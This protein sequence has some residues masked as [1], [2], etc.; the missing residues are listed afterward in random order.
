MKPKIYNIL[1]DAIEDG[2]RYGYQRAHKHTDDPDRA[3]IENEIHNAI[4][5]QIFQY[6]D[7]DKEVKNTVLT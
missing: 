6:F 1:S 5:G 2:I 7:F 4:M 3:V